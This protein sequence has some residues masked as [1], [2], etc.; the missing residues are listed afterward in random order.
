[1]QF[2]KNVK[3]IQGGMGVFVSNWRM[4]KAVARERPGITAGTVSGTGLDVVYVR[5]LQLGDPGGHIRRALS[6]F[7]TQFGTDC[8]RKI[9]G[10]YCIE[11]GKAPT[12]RFRNAPQQIARPQ[13]GGNAIPPA[14]Q[15]GAQVSLTLDEDIIELLIVTSFAEVWLAKEG[16]D[17]KIF[18]NFM[19][20]IE[21]PLIYGMYGA[22]LAGVDGVVVGAGNPDGLPEVCSRLANHK[23]VNN[24]LSVLYRESGEVFNVPFDPHLVVG[25]KLAQKPLQRPAFL[26]IVSLENLVI[27]LAESQS[28]APDGFII[29]HHTA[30]GHNAGP[31][32]ILNLDI[33]GQPIYGE[34]DEPDLQAIRQAGLPF[35]LAGGYGS[36]EKLQQSETEGAS[37]VQVGSTFALAEESGM[38]P[39]YRSAILNELK[40]G[41]DDD[42]LVQT[43]L[44]SPTGFP[45]KVVQLNDTLAN[46]AVFSA[47]RRVCDIGLLQQRGL[48][49][50]AED[51]KRQLFQRCPAAPVEDF[52]QKRGLERN[53]EGRRCLCNGLLSCAGLGQVGQHHGELY[54]E[55]AI[56]TLGNHL[57]G[58]RRLS[59]QGQTSYWVR[60]VVEDILGK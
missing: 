6:A 15:Q 42:S 40:K 23:P 58:I 35:W 18:I 55:P 54:E 56:V 29:E 37:G 1:M 51:G 32:G 46:E 25:G 60:D 45:F 16:H 4:A 11:G 49:K 41:T 5:L 24:N 47:R 53:T 12:A 59:R 17:G 20:K 34:M 38:K 43:T 8:G 21:L 13:M 30:G 50:P 44:F 9:Y 36:R 7:D 27:A 26:A 33:K 57:E 19:N 28:G 48:G 14:V 10:R 52:V 3:L 22:M 31:Q 39:V 2:L